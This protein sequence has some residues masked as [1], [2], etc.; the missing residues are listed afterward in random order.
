MQNRIFESSCAK[1]LWESRAL[2]KNGDRSRSSLHPVQ[3]LDLRKIECKAQL[4]SDICVVHKKNIEHESAMELCVRGSNGTDINQK[5]KKDF[6][7][8]VLLAEWL[9]KSHKKRKKKIFFKEALPFFESVQSLFTRRC[10]MTLSSLSVELRHAACK[11]G[12]VNYGTTILGVTG[13][14]RGSSGSSSSLVSLF[15][16]FPPVQYVPRAVPYAS[17]AQSSPLIGT[18]GHLYSSFGSGSAGKGV[19]LSQKPGAVRF[20][21]AGQ[22]RVFDVV[23]LWNAIQ[24]IVSPNYEKPKDSG[25]CL[26]FRLSVPSLAVLRSQLLDLDPHAMHI[27]VDD[28]TDCSFAQEM[29]QVSGKIVRLK[30]IPLLRQVAKRGCSPS[31]RCAVWKGILDD[32]GN[33][34]KAFGVI[35]ESR[36][37]WTLLVDRLAERDVGYSTCD[38]HYFLFENETFEI[39]STL[40]RDKT[41]AEYVHSETLGEEGKTGEKGN[42]KTAS[43][44]MFSPSGV[45]PFVG[46]SLLAAPLFFVTKQKHTAYGLFRGMYTRYWWKLSSLSSQPECL[47]S[48]C[49]AFEEFAQKMDAAAYNHCVRLGVPPL[50]IA[51]RWMCTAFAGYLHP[52]QVLLLWDRVISFDTLIMLP[53]LAAAIFAFR[54]SNVL[55]ARTPEDINNIFVTITNIEIVPLLQFYLFST[56]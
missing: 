14:S 35:G 3:V 15:L 20:G 43:V 46:I 44:E 17:T 23:D 21:C 1:V 36:K 4:C 9:K 47:A 24:S 27:G 51:F 32:R 53:L 26:H 54:S 16:S 55:A 11:A 2:L 52:L 45:I 40:L 38:E 28:L 18:G 50:L 37:K 30:F 12:P 5:Q 7:A 25:S 33:G 13:S 6:G 34:E 10:M 29:A 56:D 39:V 8:V 48:L 19:A 22:E 41:V 42:Y 49:C 31:G